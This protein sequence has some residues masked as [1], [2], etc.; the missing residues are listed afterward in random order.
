MLVLLGLLII[1]HRPLLLALIHAVAVEVAARENIQLSLRIEGTIFTNLSLQDIHAVPNGRGATPVE[2]ISIA[3]VTVNYSIPSLVRHG[4]SEF[5][6]SYILRDASIVVKPVEGTAAEKN[7]LAS[8]LHGLIQSPA[9]FSDRVEI[10]NLDLVAHVPDGE[11]AVKGLN[12]SLDPVQPGS[13]AI[14]EL[15]IPKVRT[16][17]DLKATASYANRDL[18]LRGLEIDPQIIVRTFELD[19]SQRAQGVNRLAVDGDMFGGSAQFSLLVRELPGK[20]ANNVSN[21]LAQVDSTARDLSLEKLSR[22]F[23]AGTPAI[24]SLGAAAVHITGDPNTP[25][26]WTGSMTTDAGTVHAGGVTLDKANTR[27]DLS[28]GWATFGATVFSGSNSVTA[29]ADGKLPDSLD[30]FGGAAIEGWFDVSAT[31]LH[32][33]SAEIVSGRVTGGGTFD[34]RNDTLKAQVNIKTSNVSMR[35]LDVSEGNVD[36]RVTELLPADG[37][38]PRASPLDGLET[39]IEGH[40]TDIRAGA[41]AVDSAEVSVSS[42]DGILRIA[43][44]TARRAGDTLAATGTCWLPADASAWASAPANLR[45]ELHAPSIAAFDAE[46]NLKGPDGNVEA[47]GTLANGP[48]GCDGVIAANVS[49]LRMQDFAADGLK[50][51]VSIQKSVAAI[52]TLTFSLNPTDGFSATG[53]VAMRSP[54]PYDGTV[55]AQIRDLSKF[56]AFVQGL[57]GGVAG[58][59]DLNWSGKGDLATLESTGGL[60]VSLKNARVQD[61]RA[62][63]ADIAGS[64]SPEQVDFPTFRVTSSMGDVSAVIAARNDVLRVSE[65]A[66]RQGGRALL[67]GSLSI[68]LDLR[69]PARPETLVPTNGPLFADLVSSDIAIGSLFPKGQAPGTGTARVSITARGTIDA[70]NARVIVTGSGLQAKAAATLAPASLEA[71]FT[72]L[73]SQL[74]LKARVAQPSISPIEIAGDVPLPLAQ[75]LHNREVDPQSPIQL[76]IRVPSSSL[77]VV[78]RIVPAVRFIQGTAE[79]SIDVAGTIAKPVLSGDAAIDLA[80]VRMAD[81]DMPS[82]NGFRADLAFAGNRL[83]FRQFGGNLSGGRFDVTGGVLFSDLVNPVIDLHFISHGDLILRNEDVTVRADSD[84][85]VSG[86]FAA[87]TVSGDIGITKSRFF[88]EIE[89]LPLELPGQPAPKPPTLPAANPS[90]DIAPFRDWKI[91]LKIHTKDPFII[92]GNLAQGAALIDLTLGG[93]GKAPTLDGTVRIENFV[94]S[95]PF[96]KLNVTNGFVYF[97]KDDPFIPQLNIQAA[98]SLQD[99]NINVFIYGTATDPKTVMSSEPPLPQED[100]VALLAT[101]A[102]TSNLSSG[103]AL[104]GRAAILV[105]QQLYHKFF[106]SKPQSDNESFV[107]R[108]KVDVGGVDPRTGQQEV[109]SRFKLSD[110]FYLVGDLDVG[111][112]IRGQVRYLLRF[113]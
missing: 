108:F 26:S 95:L 104:A 55:T 52:D 43:K 97:T 8:T 106:K 96:S 38:A 113:K 64:Y 42:S 51:T 67:S 47:S 88:K 74:S 10:D 28:K 99:Y 21:A 16:W 50:L 18:I 69:T 20:H 66:V 30:G 32:Q 83:T 105:L 12:L 103:N 81:P 24:G 91:A 102:T 87:T 49:A 65:I 62:I 73:G 71:D 36:A 5:L 46:P 48:S 29:H 9:L 59:L 33:L 2:A 27:L 58:A 109:S 3:E 22:Y 40:I 6:S 11:F 19:A 72:L 70:P 100:I 85:R 37:S 25:S 44:V 57:K 89:I 15:E 93:T 68:P 61:V 110:E 92:Q 54:Y 14:G 31:G 75:I 63:N 4:A 23:G 80:A 41:Y 86:P 35:D 112:E 107:S 7:D 94:A 84:V 79:A 78:T 34:L 1:F 39:E 82:V 90:L 77:V 98:S 13:L 56:N 111:G 45:F 53:H 101:G 17:H 60:Q 76:S